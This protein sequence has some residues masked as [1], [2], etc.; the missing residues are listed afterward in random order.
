MEK[1]GKDT[2]INIA[3]TSMASKI[4]GTDSD[5]FAKMVG[6]CGWRWGGWGWG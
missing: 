1:L 3:K 2:L 5:F 6:G 4:I